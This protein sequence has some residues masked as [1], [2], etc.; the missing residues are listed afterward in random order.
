MAK[1]NIVF[2]LLITI[3]STLA[4]VSA[5]RYLPIP[6]ISGVV[7]DQKSVDP[8]QVS[9]EP[10]VQDQEATQPLADGGDLQNNSQ[11]SA[12]AQAHSL[13]VQEIKQ[14][15]QYD[16]IQKVSG[17]VVLKLYAP[18]CG[19]CKMADKI[20]PDIVTYFAGKV[21]FYALDVTDSALSQQA[22]EKGLLKEMPRSIPTFVFLDKDHEVYDVHVGYMNYDAMLEKIKTVFHL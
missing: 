10:E 3:V 14:V 11:K 5:V 17:P 16:E 12:Q 19:A 9:L 6:G 21:A 22:I 18:W 15:D 4:I 7:E 8:M 13:I 2:I 1:K 20:M